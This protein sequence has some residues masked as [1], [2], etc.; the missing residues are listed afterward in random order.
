M[1]NL[2]KISVLFI[3][4]VNERLKTYLKSKL[5]QLSNLNLIFPKDLSEENLLS[6]APKASVIIGWR[7]DI[8]MLQSADQLKL[9]INPGAGVQHL[10]PI[11][12]D[13]ERKDQII[14]VNGHGNS[15]F[16]AQHAVALLLSLTN[17]IILHHDWMKQGKW[18]T[19]DS[20]AKSVPLWKKK[21]GLIGY[22][23]INKKV[24]QLLSAFQCEFSILRRSWENTNEQLLTPVT[25]YEPSEIRKF[26]G[27]IDFCIV[28]VPQTGN[29]VNMIQKDELNRLGRTGFLVSVARGQVINE[30]DLYYALNENRIA[31]AAIDV[32]YDYSPEPNT[33]NQKF[34][35]HFPF[36]ELPN[37]VLSPHRAASP[38]DNLDRWD[39]VVENLTK[40]SEGKKDFINQVNIANEY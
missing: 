12:R 37:I 26:M 13:L 2:S 7:P 23:A 22:G 3:W 5:E 1:E 9:F 20:E 10:I 29:T 36:H 39:E 15:Y 25:R 38:F 31:G 11:F 8:K 35:Y 18:R 27:N 24:H 4:D 21:V 28:A 14:L 19:G 40:I 32:W 6:L 17:K 30:E 34:P 33:D 16:T